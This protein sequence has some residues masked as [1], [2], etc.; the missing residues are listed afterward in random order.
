MPRVKESPPPERER[1]G[2]ADEGGCR[3]PGAAAG[4]A[5]SNLP[6]RHASADTSHAH[7]SIEPH[8]QGKTAPKSVASR[9]T[10]ETPELVY[11]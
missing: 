6:C 11:L 7:V 3:R 4:A 5:I 2:I 8:A 10:R 9:Y 1:G